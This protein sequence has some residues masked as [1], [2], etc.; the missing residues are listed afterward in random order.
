VSCD[1]RFTETLEIDD[2]GGIEDC[3]NGRRRCG[4]WFSGSE[5]VVRNT[6]DI[7]NRYADFAGGGTVV[8]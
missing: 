5:E 3:G 1:E 4:V 2:G 6:G 8:H 7:D